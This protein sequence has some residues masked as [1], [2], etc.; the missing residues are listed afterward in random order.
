[1]LCGFIV[2]GFLGL[3]FFRW[4]TVFSYFPDLIFLVYLFLSF[5]QF[6]VILYHSAFCFFFGLLSFLILRNQSSFPDLFLFFFIKLWSFLI[7]SFFHWFGLFLFQGTNQVFL[8]CFC[9]LSI[10]GHFLFPGGLFCLWFGLFLYYGLVFLFCFTN[11]FRHFLFSEVLFSLWFS[12][13]F[14]ESVN[15]PGMYVFSCFYQFVV[16]SYFPGLFS[17]TVSNFAFFCFFIIFPSFLIFWGL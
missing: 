11:L 4:I 16:I 14:T 2:G 9:F 5:Y 7:F 13:Y 6:L 8:V 17:F 1:M 10:C 15:F 3:N 12:F